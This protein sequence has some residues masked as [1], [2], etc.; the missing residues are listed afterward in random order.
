MKSRFKI[1]SIKTQREVLGVRAPSRIEERRYLLFPKDNAVTA[2]L[3]NNELYEPWLY[4]FIYLNNIDIK[5]TEIIDVG[6]NNGQISIEFGNLVG[7]KGKVHSFEPQRIVFYQ[8]CGNVFFNGLDN[9][10]CYNMALGNSEGFI[11]IEAPDYHSKD[12]VNF[13]DV[14]VGLGFEKS[15]KVE[16][17]KLDSFDFENVSVIKIDVQGFELDVIE[18]AEKTINKHRPVIFIEIEENQ[19]QKYGKTSEDVIQKLEGFGYYVQRFLEDLPF[20]TESGKCL[21][22]FAVPKEKFDINTLKDR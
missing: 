5:S 16:I 15:E 1:D 2:S 12:W 10:F 4:N 11:D 18:G 3:Y 17:K 6:A 22:F 14:H 7:D 21:D 19:L 13:G 9:V 8:L 20:F